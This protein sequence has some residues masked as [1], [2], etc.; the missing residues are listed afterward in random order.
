MFIVWKNYLIAVSIYRFS[1]ETIDILFQQH[2]G[3][4][5]SSSV[6]KNEVDLQKVSIRSENMYFGGTFAWIISM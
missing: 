1:L 6:V 2:N 3:S 4:F 5:S